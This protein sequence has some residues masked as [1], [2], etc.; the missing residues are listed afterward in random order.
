MR[1]LPL[2]VG[3]LFGVLLIKSEV[4][5]WSRIQSMFLFQEAHMYLTMGSAVAVS[6]L[7]VALIKWLRMRTI[8]GDAPVMKSRRFQKGTVIGGL[9]FGMGW[10]T[11]GA[12]PGPIYAQIGSGEALALVTLAGALL[13]A[14]LYAVLRPRLPH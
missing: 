12:C 6:I 11:T 8:S 14:Y 9:L 13:G 3:L 2:F 5:S 4:T 10:A 1:A 7:S